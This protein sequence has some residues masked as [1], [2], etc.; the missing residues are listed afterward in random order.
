MRGSKVTVPARE[1]PR[2]LH[3]E[4]VEPDVTRTTG[5][6]ERQGLNITRGT[7]RE[8]QATYKLVCTLSRKSS[9]PRQIL[10]LEYQI[11]VLK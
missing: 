11:N 5:A 1:P 8:G 9:S 2:T 4:L 3:W 7:G 10:S 6:Q